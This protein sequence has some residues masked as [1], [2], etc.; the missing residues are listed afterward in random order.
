MC[1]QRSKYSLPSEN[2]AQR[3]SAIT[4]HKIAVLAR[5]VSFIQARVI[6]IEGVSV[7][8]MPL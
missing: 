3:Q 8:K 6:G 4:E 2:I 5:F 1:K 7:E